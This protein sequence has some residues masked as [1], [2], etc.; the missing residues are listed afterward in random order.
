MSAAWH[1]VGRRSPVPLALMG[2][3]FYLSAQSDP[4]PDLPAVARMAGHAGQFGLL[5]LLWAWALEPR[6][7]LRRA[8]SAAAA[9]AFVYAISDEYHQTHVPGRDG[10]PVDVAID[11]VGITIAVLLLRARVAR[12]RAGSR[13]GSQPRARRGGPG[14]RR[15]A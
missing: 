12:S 6:L 11:A 1:A 15:R 13:R 2:V 3:I 14:I 10:D 9:I 7:G 8:T 4:G 5:T